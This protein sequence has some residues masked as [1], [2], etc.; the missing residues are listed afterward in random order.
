MITDNMFC[1]G[2]LDWS[3]DAC[4]VFTA[5]PNSIRP[6]QISLDSP[7]MLLVFLPTGRLGRAAGVRGR[8][9]ALPVR[10]HQLG[11]RLCEGV[12]TRRLHQSDQLQPMDRREDEAVVHRCWL[13]VPSEVTV[14]LTNCSCCSLL[15]F[16][17]ALEDKAGN[18]LYVFIYLI[19]Q[20]PQNDQNQWRIQVLFVHPKPD[21]SNS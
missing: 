13:H 2:R 3:Q 15:F 17:V 8:R 12:S 5:S 7:S 10:G 20:I 1:A 19:Y 21:I 4:E 9:H 6:P 18:I 14:R 16:S 11:R